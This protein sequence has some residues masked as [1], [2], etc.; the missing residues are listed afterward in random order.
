MSQA[1]GRSHRNLVSRQSHRLGLSSREAADRFDQLQ[2]KLIPLWKSISSMSQEQQTIIVVPSMTM[3]NDLGSIEKA[4]E[5]RFL[6]LLLLLRQPQARL[7]YI[8]S[9]PVQRAI[10]DYYLGLLPGVVPSHARNRL[11]LLSPG[12]GSSKPLTEKILERPQI[13]SENPR[14]RYRSKSRSP[15]AFQ[16]YDIRT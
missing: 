3:D 2:M 9:M 14:H 1:T 12:D 7:I 5:E 6:F 15:C 16:Y 11:F 4:Y 8:T 10:I 13:H